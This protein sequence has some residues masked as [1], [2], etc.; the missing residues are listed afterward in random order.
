MSHEYQVY[1]VYQVYQMHQVYQ[2]YQVYQMYQKDQDQ[3]S[4]ATYISD[5]VF[6]NWNS[7]T[8]LR[9]IKIEK[10]LTEDKRE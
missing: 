5:V 10:L 3:I 7:P 6:F 8:K 2:V 4:V 9:L 1:Q